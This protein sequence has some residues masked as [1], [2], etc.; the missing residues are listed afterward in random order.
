MDKLYCSLFTFEVEFFAPKLL[1]LRPS[2]FK[3]CPRPFIAFVKFAAQ[4]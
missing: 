4:M 1:Y 3:K 2:V